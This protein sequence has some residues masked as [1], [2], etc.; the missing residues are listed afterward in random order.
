MTPPTGSKLPLG[1]ALLLLLLSK[2][3]QCPTLSWLQMTAHQLYRSWDSQEQRNTR[4][5]AI[6]L[7]QCM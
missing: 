5:V 3:S 7:P 6:S 4:W 1:Q 2:Q